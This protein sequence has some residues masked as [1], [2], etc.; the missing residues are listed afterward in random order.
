ME[1]RT[2][3]PTTYTVF[4]RN[5]GFNLA[6]RVAVAGTSQTRRRGLLGKE[7]IEPE[8]GLWIAPCEAVHTFGMRTVI[9]V[10]FLD[11]HNRVSK[12][13]S[14]LKPSRIAVCLKATSVLELAGGNLAQGE[15]RLG[16]QLELNCLSVC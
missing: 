4:N 1:K 2:E 14:N 6:T 12:L 8:A 9:D 16:D 7:S 3:A 13:I 5:R 11:R 15:T 10:V